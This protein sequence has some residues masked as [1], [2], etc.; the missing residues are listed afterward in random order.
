MKKKLTLYSMRTAL[1]LLLMLFTCHLGW[2]QTTTINLGGH[3]FTIASDGSYLISNEADL[4]ALA[5]YVNSGNN[6]SGMTFKLNNDITMTGT[7]TPIGG[8]NTSPGYPFNGTFDGNH[9]TIRNLTVNSANSNYVGLFGYTHYTT[10][11]N[12]DYGAVIKDLTL[13]NCDITGKAYVGGIVG[14]AYKARIQNCRVSGTIQGSVSGANNHGGIAGYI[15]ESTITDCAVSGTILTTVSN[16][17][18]GGVVGYAESTNAVTHCENSASINGSGNNHGGIVGYNSS[19]NSTYSQCLNTGSVEGDVFVG[20][21]AGLHNSVNGQFN[22]YSNCY[23]HLSQGNTLPAFEYLYGPNDQ[24]VHSD[25][26]GKAERAYLIGPGAHIASFTVS[27]TSGYA[28][29]MISGNNYGKPGDL[30]LTIG[31]DLTN[32]ETFITYACVGGTLTNLTSEDGDHTLTITDTDVTIN[33]IVSNNN[34]IDI[35]GATIDPIADQRWKGGE[36]VIP[37]PN[38]IIVKY[39][40]NTLVYGTDYLVECSNNTATGPATATIIGINGYKNRKSANFNIVDFPLLNPQGTNASDNPYLI[41]TEEDL[42]ALAA[43]VNNGARS[44]GFYRQTA[45]IVCTGEHTAIGNFKNSSNTYTFQGTF[46]GNDGETQHTISN[47]T[48]N[49][50]D[51]DYQGLFGRIYNATVKNVVLVNCDIT[52]GRFTGGIAGHMYCPS[53]TLDNCSVSGAIKVAEGKSKDSHGGIVGYIYYGTV[54]NCVNTASV[55]GNGA[56]HAG[57]VGELTSGTFMNH[58]FNAGTIAGDSHI[59]SL[60]GTKSGTITNSYHTVG[61]T[62]GVGYYGE[63]Y[64][65]DVS[66]AEVVAKITAGELVTITYPESP[67]YVWNSENLYKSGT[68]VEL[69]YNLPEGKVFNMYTVNSGAISAAATM[70]GEHTLTGFS[71]HVVINGLYVDGMIDLTNGSCH[72]AD[73][74]D[75]T[76][77][78][79]MQHPVPVV[80]NNNDT[81][82]ENVHYTVSYS[83]GCTNAGNYSVTVTGMGC[84]QHS[85][86]KNFTIN[87]FD[88]ADCEVI[89]EDYVYTG[90]AFTAEP[91][92][93]H[94]STVLTEGE[95][96]DYTFTTTP[97]TILATGNYTL[98]VTGHNNYTGTKEVAFQV[99]YAKPTDLI[100]TAISADLTSASL[101][102]TEN[103][104]ANQWTVEYSTNNTFGN[105]QTFTVNTTSATL[106]DL[107]PGTTYYVRVKAVYGANEESEWSDVTT[108]ETILKWTIGS[109]TSASYKLP[110]ENSYYYT[111]SQQIY[112]ATEMGNK[113]GTILSIDFY[114]DNTDNYT[115]NRNLTI[116]M[117]NTDKSSFGKSN[118]WIAVTD[119]NKVFTGT[120]NFVNHTWT[121]IILDTPF[122]YDGTKNLAVVVDD[123]TASNS[124]STKFRT[125][126]CADNQSMVFYSQSTNPDPKGDNTYH[127]GD[128]YSYKNQV[129][130]LFGA[131]RTV[132]GYGDST[133]SDKWVLIASPVPGSMSPTEVVNLIASEATHYDLYRFNQSNEDEWENYKAHNTN[134]DDFTLVNGQG[135]LYA[136]K[137]DVTLGF[138]GFVNPANSQ[139]VSLTY[140][141]ENPNASMHGWNLVGNP[142]NA[143]VTS[144]LPYYRMN[145]N[146]DG[147]ESATNAT[148]VS[149]MEGIFVHTTAEEVAAGTNKVIFTKQ[150]RGDS[151][152]NGGK[153]DMNLSQANNRQVDNAI[154]R[155]DGG[156]GLEKFSF[157]EGSSKIYMP[158]DGK[159]YAIVN[160]EAQGEMPV[161]FKAENNGSYKLSFTNENVEFGYLHLIDNLTGKDVNLLATPSYTF[162]AKTTDYESRF[163]LVFNVGA[164]DG[165]ENFA[166]INDG[167]IILNGE[168]MLQVVDVMGRILMQEENTTRVSTNGMTPGVYV[169]RLISGDSVRTQKIVVK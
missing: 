16:N 10:I 15:Y 169:L 160:A 125:F 22:N 118:D 54:S 7:H 147:F 124:W 52:G 161:S 132:T 75:L 12:V 119:A 102:W 83:E 63:E 164:A 100:R 60:T 9:N 37:N 40:S 163:K 116:Y 130:I 146:G 166:F 135:Y 57:I 91:T 168:G 159:Y 67:D 167:N 34:G 156:K 96:A 18:Y 35:N 111:M 150:N 93:K 17:S 59:G 141:T 31:H 56:N 136:S 48:I 29:S 44:G 112:T 144:S 137:A 32:N 85:L 39:N 78:K 61:T 4:E 131:S 49:K 41:A 71:A 81:L 155:F 43:I 143:Q 64:G 123:N 80:T 126:S 23:Y 104:C 114:R 82:V 27:G 47:L 42:E 33:A 113:P 73:I 121:T 1:G 50:P 133:E 90:T 14:N 36:P 105:S 28:T 46:D 77:N 110:I 129:R 21:I 58:C 157:R 70:T 24:H 108:F 99:Y 153:L 151:D 8:Y 97:A 76:F 2:A 79:Q 68:I 13:A 120:V 149:P 51:D 127:N 142:F 138:P 65:T 53:K 103:G 158:V 62:G 84:Y 117:V 92:V 128:R 107:T 94:G 109:G 140:S 26:P 30:T 20:S 87:P 6:A 25:K 89:M 66:G 106:N 11:D 88:V 134:P 122:D 69:A 55:T 162:E 74:E 154:I 98:T 145:E 115:C 152:N 38:A 95:Q 86:T 72:I 5:S 101:S 19:Y 165:S 3:E 148:A 45:D 139:I